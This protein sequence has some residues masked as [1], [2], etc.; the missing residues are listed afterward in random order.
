M[1][2]LRKILFHVKYVSISSEKHKGGM[3][4]QPELLQQAF[5]VNVSPMLAILTRD[6]IFL[7]N[8]WSQPFWKGVT[9]VLMGSIRLFD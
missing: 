7:L 4:L 3:Q 2:S 5:V 6:S 9:W 1:A 8:V